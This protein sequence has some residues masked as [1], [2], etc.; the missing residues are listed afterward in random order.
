MYAMY[1]VY[2]MYVMYN[3]NHVREKGGETRKKKRDILVEGCEILFY[4][5]YIIKKK[6]SI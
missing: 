5:L 3:W 4:V 6:E 1:V 2:A